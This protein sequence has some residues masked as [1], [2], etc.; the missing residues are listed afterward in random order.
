KEV[1]ALAERYRTEVATVVRIESEPEQAILREARRHNLIVMGVNRRPGEVLFFGD[2]AAAVLKA[3]KASVLFVARERRHGEHGAPN[4]RHQITCSRPRHE[5]NRRRPGALWRRPAV[6]CR[7]PISC[8]GRNR[9]VRH[10]GTVRRWGWR[11][12]RRRQESPS[13]A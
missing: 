10:T 7:G 4:S 6:L 8:P 11:R 2:V 9:V 5:P 12:R 13:E 3:T 1:V